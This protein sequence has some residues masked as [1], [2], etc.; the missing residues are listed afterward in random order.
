MKKNNRVVFENIGGSFQFHAR[1]AED[2]HQILEL[3][4]TAW[5]ALCVPV[6][7]LNGDPEFFKALDGDQNGMVRV[8]EVKAAISWLSNVLCNIKVLNEARNT[9]L[10]EELNCE[11]PDGKLLHDFAAE[12]AAE[13]LNEQ[14]QL[15]L[16]LIRN[17]L[18]AVTSGPLAGDG[19]LKL[20][21]LEK[22]EALGLY[23]DI[24]TL[25]NCQDKLT[26]DI[27]EK[28]V[29]D[30]ESFVAWAKE[31]AK[32]QFRKNDP[33]PFYDAYK[34]VAAKID[35]YFR[36]CEL[37][38][39]DPAHAVRFTLDPSKLPE[40]DLQDQQ[41]IDEVLKNAPLALP[42]AEG[43]LELT[44]TV[45]PFYQDKLEAFAKLF[46][47]KKL[48]LDEWKELKAEFV[49]Y[50]DYLSKA[51][52]D[53]AGQLGRE[54]LEKYLD[55]DRKEINLLRQLLAEDKALSGVVDSL[56]KLEQLLLYCRYMLE[57]VNNFVSFDAFF[58]P[59]QIS[60]LQAGRLIMDG[61]SY[62]LAV[63]IDDVA[64]HK[65]IA[66][67]SNLCLLYL[68]VVS[69]GKVSVKRKLAVAVTG[70][71]L[72]RIYIGK[73]AFFIDN[74]NETYNGKIVDMVDGPIS[75]GQTLWAP[76]RRLSEALGDKL[77]KLTDFSSTEKQL[78]QAIDKGKLPPAAPAPQAN[79]PMSQR[80]LG[81]GS[82][83][84]LAGGLSVAA[85]G[86]GV[87]FVL[88]AIT[89]AVTSI[90]ALPGYVILIWIFVLLAIFLI[91]TAIFA[92]LKLRKRNLTLFLEA[93]G[94]A[95]N[96]PMRLNLHVS[97]IFTHGTEYPER[98]HFKVVNKVPHRRSLVFV[99]LI[100]IVL[101]A[102]AGALWY[103][104]SKNA[105]SPQV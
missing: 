59:E 41:K 42:A 101:L 84:L 96:L 48:S 9:L 97:G 12:H 18:K 31:T 46:K 4:A 25:L 74:N 60:M 58:D 50:I 71:S 54:K 89:N 3:D 68:D 70:G 43:E 57:F 19:L 21:A 105:V 22:S 63:W 103:L 29:T 30:A 77:Q 66:M 36:F 35:E 38:R 82:V 91:P 51:Q 62:N 2:L 15:E 44:K 10:I 5:A 75:F 100:T 8:D 20:K 53:L 23:K 102:A 73:P 17:K 24:S 72:N 56:R 52:G 98:T 13:L 14:K 67:R 40:L 92:F 78:A 87:S 64:S 65:K 76:F 86:A 99:V 90:S 39:I 69:S 55:G 34:A 93:G 61:K 81:N 104:Q 7:S 32:P 83:M 1:R 27:L 26:S 80:F 47:I 79:V 85:L 33:V 49:E 94:W 16:S 6:A 45:N 28:F 95:V 11:H 88:K 37:I